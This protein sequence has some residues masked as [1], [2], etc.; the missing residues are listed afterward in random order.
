METAAYW[1]EDSYILIIAVKVLQRRNLV[2][3]DVLDIIHTLYI[4]HI[5]GG[6]VFIIM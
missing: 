1:R 5:S 4:G 6:F 2:G 3:T